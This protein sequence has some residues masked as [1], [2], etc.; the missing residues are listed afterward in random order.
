MIETLRL[1]RECW[2][3]SKWV[4]NNSS[5][6]I[7]HQFI[8]TNWFIIRWWWWWIPLRM[9]SGGL[10][11][12]RLR[13]RLG[14]ADRGWARS[15]WWKYQILA[16]GPAVSDKGT[17][18]SSLQ[19]RISTKTQSSEANKVFIKRKIRTVCVNRHMGTQGESCWVAPSGQFELLLW[20]ISC[21]LSGLVHSPC[22]VYIRTFPWIH[23]HLLANMDFTEKELG[24]P[25]HN[26]PLAS[27]EAFC[28]CVFR[29]TSWLWEQE[30]CGLG[31][32]QPP[33][34]IVLLSL[35]WSFSP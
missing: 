26:S 28:G 6:P 17:G 4:I 1:M 33:P 25:W 12:Q 15:Q 18:P 34:L 20:G 2:K 13:A 22:L 16:T 21:I 30:I 31:R 10:G 24:I 8:I 5:S 29:E 32:A 3:W 9:I 7:S 19:K 23:M 35:S 11:L 27:K 14:F